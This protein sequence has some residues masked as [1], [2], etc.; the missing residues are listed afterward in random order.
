MKNIVKMYLDLGNPCALCKEMNGVICFE[1]E[2][3]DCAEFFCQDC[4]NDKEQ[5]CRAIFESKILAEKVK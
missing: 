3:F 1:S 2:K 5:D 4:I